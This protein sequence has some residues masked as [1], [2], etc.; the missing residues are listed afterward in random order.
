VLV[1]C[2]QYTEFLLLRSE[3]VYGIP[4]NILSTLLALPAFR[5]APDDESRTC[6]GRPPDRDPGVSVSSSSSPLL[7]IVSKGGDTRE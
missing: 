1:V 4:A 5:E 7:L 3:A 2:E 6:Q